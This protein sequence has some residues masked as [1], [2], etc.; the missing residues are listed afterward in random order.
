MEI[1]GSLN[2]SNWDVSKV[3]NM[4]SMFEKSTFNG[5]LNISNWNVSKVTNM[6]SM[7][8]DST[9]YSKYFHGELNISNWNVSNVTNMESMFYGFNGKLNISKWDV[10]KVTNMSYMFY[11][12]TVEELN[13]SNWD[14]S[15][16]TNMSYMFYDSNF[17]QNI[18]N[19][20]V[21]NV[22]NMENFG[23]DN[24][25]KNYKPKFYINLDDIKQYIED[26]KDALTFNN[27]KPDYH[28][29]IDSSTNTITVN[30]KGS[31]KTIQKDKKYIYIELYKTLYEIDSD[32]NDSDVVNINNIYFRENDSD[33]NDSDE[34]DSDDSDENDSDVVNIN[35]IY[36]RENNSDE[37]DINFYKKYVRIDI[38]K[39]QDVG[40][41][42]KNLLTNLSENIK[43]S[44]FKNIGDNVY[45]L[46]FDNDRETNIYEQLGMM[47]GYFILNGQS[48]TFNI[49]FTFLF[50]LMYP[51]NEY[52]NKLID[53]FLPSNS[54]QDNTPRS[55]PHPHSNSSQDNTPRSHPH[56]NSSEDINKDKL[57]YL[58]QLE[59]IV[60]NIDYINSYIIYKDCLK[61]D[62]NN[63]EN[64]DCFFKD[65]PEDD[66]NKCLNKNN[67]VDY[68]LTKKLEEIFPSENSKIYISNMSKGFKNVIG[69]LEK[70]LNEYLNVELN[71][72]DLND[73]IISLKNCIEILSV[74][75][76]HET[77][78]INSLYFQNDE[79]N[80]HDDAKFNEIK[81]KIL[82]IIDNKMKSLNKE[83]VRQFIKRF[84]TQY[85]AK[86]YL[87]DK[88]KI[89]FKI[90]NKKDNSIIS[91]HT[92]FNEIQVNISDSQINENTYE[93]F[94]TQL[95][96]FYGN[97]NAS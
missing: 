25:P 54:S 49:D 70:E 14:V 30:Y 26:Q 66:P 63:I 6:E 72:E 69:F 60:N 71:E 89:I 64:T 9:F 46:K 13:L 21:L 80:Q 34:N 76:V 87:T 58:L 68:H 86:M 36:F 28:L 77:K 3:T 56:S 97:F 15:K 18:S 37:I 96:D 55:H 52:I 85:T 11:N 81:T 8:Q 10:S 83:E 32:E 88:E 79:Y 4:E 59:S 93:G 38:G 33:K 57:S 29:E 95:F 27:D 74:S 31:K 94:E 90:S 42:T 65:D 20:D 16:V 62:I 50:Y 19:W 43:D 47:I 44:F 91:I 5:E 73:R 39:A 45:I 17:N 2:L 78:F 40:G 1:D 48:L 92:C 41:C 51:N 7:F 23:N 53:S 24:M 75:L 22:M 67:V 84:N 35:N 12:S 82:Q 61:H